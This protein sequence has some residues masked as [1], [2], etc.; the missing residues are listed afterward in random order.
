MLFKLE[1]GSELK[2]LRYEE[3]AERSQLTDECYSGGA[4]IF[5]RFVSLTRSGRIGNFHKRFIFKGDR[6][7]SATDDGT[8]SSYKTQG[9]E[10]DA[11]PAGGY[12][13]PLF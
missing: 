1:S 8:A 6:H 2:Q 10:D 7:L 4:E 11:T 9:L 5:L 3:R 12:T 13:S